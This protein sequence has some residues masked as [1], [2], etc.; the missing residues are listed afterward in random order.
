MRGDSWILE[1]ENLVEAEP[2]PHHCE[3]QPTRQLARWQPTRHLLLLQRAPQLLNPAVNRVPTRRM[4]SAA[5]EGASVGGSAA[6]DAGVGE[7]AEGGIG[8]RRRGLGVTSTRHTLHFPSAITLM[9]TLT[10]S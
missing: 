7:A 6:G 8:S 1:T 3:M 2:S 4:A 10:S 5:I 9:P